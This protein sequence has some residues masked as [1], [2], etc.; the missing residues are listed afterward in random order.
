[1]EL[2]TTREAAERLKISEQTVRA[3]YHSGKLRGRRVG[4]RLIRIDASS[5]GIQPDPPR[6]KRPVHDYIGEIPKWK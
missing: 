1:M 6:R 4:P 5:L 3:M 2:L